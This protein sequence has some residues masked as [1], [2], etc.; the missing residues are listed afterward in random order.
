MREGAGKSD[1]EVK[2]HWALDHA[3]IIKKLMDAANVGELDDEVIDG[4]VGVV[5]S[6]RAKKVNGGQA[7][8]VSTEVEEEGDVELWGEE[9]DSN[10][11]GT[12]GSSRAPGAATS[13]KTPGPRLSMLASHS[14]A[15][16]STPNIS[17]VATSI[18]EDIDRPAH[19]T[20]GGNTLALER[21]LES[22]EKR[23]ER[24]EEKY[25]VL[26]KKNVELVTENTELRLRVQL[27]EARQRWEQERSHIY[28]GS[29]LQGQAAAGVPFREQT[30]RGL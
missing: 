30:F 17:R 12:A 13:S 1:E 14:S 24:I 25:D 3:R 8:M 6:K 28:N 22:Y 18:E 23:M 20:C 19:P 27:F 7:P 10:T 26:E 29:E 9:E 11:A 5:S 15:Q 4:A 21:V 16:L 2:E